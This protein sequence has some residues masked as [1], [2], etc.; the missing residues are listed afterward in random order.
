MKFGLRGKLFGVLGVLIIFVGSS[1]GVWLESNLRQWLEARIENQ[2]LQETRALREVLQSHNLPQSIEHLDPL[3][4][5]L[6]ATLKARVTIIAPNGDLLG[7]SRLDH[8]EILTADDHSRRPEVLQSITQGQGSSRR[9]SDTIKT[10]MLYVAVPLSSTGRDGFVR[11]SLPLDEVEAT[12]NQARSLVLYAILAALLIAVLISALASHLLTRALRQVLDSLEVQPL[13]GNLDPAADELKTLL[14]SSQQISAELKLRVQQLAAQRDRFAS[15]LDSVDAAVI[16][17]DSRGRLTTANTSAHELLQITAWA[18]ERELELSNLPQEIKDVLRSKKALNESEI[19]LAGPPQRNLLAR[20]VRTHAGGLVAVFHDIT[21]IKRLTQ[22]RTDFVANAS[23]ELRTPVAVLQA[24]AETLLDGALEDPAAARS[25]VA[26]IHRHSVRLGRLLRDLLDLSRIEAGRYAVDLE[27]AEIAPIL[28]ST[29]EE[30]SEEA[31]KNGILLTIDC[32]PGLK[33]VI[34]HNALQQVLLNL[35]DNAIKYAGAT[36]QIELKASSTPDRIRIEVN[37]DGPGIPLKDRERVFERF[38]RVDPGR[39]RALG[40]T[41]LG[42][43]IVKHLVQSMG[44]GVGVSEAPGGG[45]QL[46]LELPAP[47]TTALAQP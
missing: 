47:L 43:A 35:L 44:G 14:V 10:D 45:A 25:F 31:A 7:D 32:S 11:M 36:G 29:V 37:D 20:T 16:A 2:L 17:M 21:E 13:G 6:G 38:F 42:L 9:Y 24:N 27:L 26:A 4:D 28:E 46:W 5:R 3:A 30:C 18:T 1:T 39:S 40:G 41:G 8:A 34:D 33:G 22:V 15:V 23:H 19:E 12:L